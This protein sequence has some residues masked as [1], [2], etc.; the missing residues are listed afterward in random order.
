MTTKAP[1]TDVQAVREHVEEQALLEYFDWYML[2]ELERI[3]PTR[4]DRKQALREL[5]RERFVTP[6]EANGYRPTP[7][8]VA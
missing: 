8:R 4:T 1:M 7:R 3:G 2:L 6:A 5:E